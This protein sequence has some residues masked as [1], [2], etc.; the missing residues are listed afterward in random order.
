MKNSKSA[1]DSPPF[2]TEREGMGVK[3]REGIGREREGRIRTRREGDREGGMAEKV[4]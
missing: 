3:R 4:S 2:A 1:T